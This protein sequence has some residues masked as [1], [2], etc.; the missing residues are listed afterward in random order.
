M[1]AVLL[2]IITRIVS[3]EREPGLAINQYDNDQ[4]RQS[5]PSLCNTA[6]NHLAVLGSQHPAH[7][8]G[9]GNE[10]RLPPWVGHGIPPEILKKT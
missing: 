8:V 7:P 9:G 1:L 2:L 3:E 10:E 5:L 6:G 4:S